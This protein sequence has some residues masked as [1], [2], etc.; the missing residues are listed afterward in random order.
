[1]IAGTQEHIRER[2]ALKRA[3][4][5]LMHSQSLLLELSDINASLGV[6]LT[7][8]DSWDMRYRFRTVD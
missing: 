5:I 4:I 3:D 6:F 7:T 1:M 8:G 2:A